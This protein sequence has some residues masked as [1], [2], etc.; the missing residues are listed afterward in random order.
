MLDI[1][2]I[3]ESEPIK[4]E[5]IL[6]IA[7]LVEKTLPVIQHQQRNGL[8]K[9]ASSLFPLL[10]GQLEKTLAEMSEVDATELAKFFIDTA[11]D[12]DEKLCR[13][14]TFTPVEVIGPSLSGKQEA[15]KLH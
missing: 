3:R 2:K 5:V 9:L 15:E 8:G 14:E 12:L 13:L 1:N 6:L 4:A 7:Q 11:I 10:L